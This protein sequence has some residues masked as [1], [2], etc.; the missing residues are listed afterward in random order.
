VQR[1][2]LVAS[3]AL[4]NTA[5]SHFI[6]Q[7]HVHSF[8]YDLH[9]RMLTDHFIG[10]VGRSPF[11]PGYHMNAFLVDFLRYYLCRPPYARNCVYE[12]KLFPVV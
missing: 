10:G 1:H 9:I 4:F 6:R 11:R 2:T 8:C 3:R 5:V 12:G 7:S